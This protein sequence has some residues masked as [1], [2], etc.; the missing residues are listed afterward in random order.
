M[1]QWLSKFIFIAALLLIGAGVILYRLAAKPP[2]ALPKPSILPSPSLSPSPSPSPSPLSFSDMNRL[3]GPCVYTPVLMYHHVAI[4]AANLTVTTDYFRKQLQYLRDRGHNPVS[5]AD[6]NAFFNQGQG[7][8]NKPVLLTFDDAYEDFYTYAYPLL[9]EFNFKAVVFVPTGLVNNPGY[10]SWGQIGEMNG[11]GLIEF[12]N[13][14][15]SHHNAAGTQE[16]IEK[17]VS[18]ADTQLNEHGLNTTKVFAY[19]YGFSTAVAKQILK[20]KGYGLAFTTVP[21]SAL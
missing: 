11:S 5:L 8:G 20:T 13:H 18:L 9:R 14:T 1:Q 4:D 2:A 16:T 15:W 10:L 3:Y 6:L 17:E 12:A 19:P 21:G 7:L